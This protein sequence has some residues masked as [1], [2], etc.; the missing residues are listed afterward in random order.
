MSWNPNLD[1]FYY[2]NFTSIDD[3]LAPQPVR[4]DRKVYT[5]VVLFK[6]DDSGLLFVGDKIKVESTSPTAASDLASGLVK[7]F[8][9]KTI[10]KLRDAIKSLGLTNQETAD[11]LGMSLS[12][13]MKLLAKKKG[14]AIEPS[15]KTRREVE[16]FLELYNIIHQNT[17]KK[18]QMRKT[19]RVPLL[20]FGNRTP[21]EFAN[22]IQNYK[23][24]SV[25]G[26][27][28]RMYA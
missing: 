16:L 26:I 21:L 11:L 4:Q 14:D 6:K 15:Y 12:N 25:L 19:M 10:I 18:F 24:Q 9:Y 3:K 5:K 1:R 28:K 2:G 20:A 7:E 8:N 13:I 27:F 22:K 23:L 17:E